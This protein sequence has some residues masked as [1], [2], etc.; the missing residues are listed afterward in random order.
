MDEC[1][2]RTRL[3]DQYLS[4]LDADQIALKV[5]NGEIHIDNVKHLLDLMTEEHEKGIQWE[6]G[7][8]PEHLKSEMDKLQKVLD[9]IDEKTQ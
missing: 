8:E 1:H 3:L 4:G 6:K 9:M 7:M 2:R 5:H